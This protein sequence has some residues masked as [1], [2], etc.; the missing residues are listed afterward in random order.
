MIKSFCDDKTEAI[1]HGRR[2]KRLETNLAKR[3]RK[4]LE[5][6]NA[7]VELE[8]LYFPPSNK[9]HKLQGFHPLRYTIRV[10]NQWRISFEWE[11]GNAYDVCFED[12]H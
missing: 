3:A 12:Y 8:D 5:Y 2:V 9:F 11:D 6:L 7:A 1:Y 10:S 4:R